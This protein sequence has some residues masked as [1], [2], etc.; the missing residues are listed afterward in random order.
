MGRREE[1]IAKI[2][3]LMLQPERIRNIGIAAHIDHGKTTLSDNLLA[4]AGMIS[5][6]LAGK[7]LVLDFDEQEQARGITINAANVSMVHNYEGKDYLINLIDT[8]GHVD[9]GGDVTRAM[10]AIDGVIIVVDAVEGVM[11]QTETVVRQ[12]LREYVKPVLFINKVDRLIRELKLTPQ[13]M[14]ERFSKIIMDVNRLIQR[15]A[16]EEYKKKWIVRVEDGSVAFGSAY[17]NWAL[18]V[19]FMQ[20]TGVK[21]NEIIDLTLKGDNKTLR[22][23][24]PL[25]VVVL[26]MVV[27]HLPN[28]IEAQKYRIPHLW[29]GDINS[30]IGQA[31]LNCDPKGKMVMVVTKIIIDKHAGEVATGR[32]WSGTV[33]SGMEVHLIN[34][35]RK[36]RIQQVGI[37]MGPE[38]INMDAVPAGNIVAVTGLRDAMAGETVAQEPIEPFEALHYVSEPVVT[39]A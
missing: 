13:Q 24:A 23:K 27:R 30:E 31:M 10:R 2:K 12:A 36:A 11:P 5:E 29:Q 16:P 18:S 39:V 17:Y 7:Q 35:K 14:M 20:R 34:S 19:P 37:Y 9:F 32:V 15:Y 21:F 25:H 4:G 1:M 33:K 8:P 22:Q 38:R 6:E 28:P 3:E 26:D